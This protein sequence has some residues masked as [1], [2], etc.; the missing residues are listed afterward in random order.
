MAVRSITVHSD[1]EI[2]RKLTLTP[3]IAVTPFIAAHCS[4]V[5]YTQNP[6]WVA[7]RKLTL[8]PFIWIFARLKESLVSKLTRKASLIIRLIGKRTPIE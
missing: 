5:L 4:G 7:Q 3:F 8:T 1:S 2:Y 6:A